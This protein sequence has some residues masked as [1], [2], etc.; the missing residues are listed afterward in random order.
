[1]N[2]LNVQG[3]LVVF[4]LTLIVI[5]CNW[6]VL[7]L[8]AEYRFKKKTDYND[9]KNVL[10]DRVQDLGWVL[11]SRSPP[12]R[13]NRRYSNIACFNISMFRRLAEES[14]HFSHHSIDPG[15]QEVSLVLVMFA[16][17]SFFQQSLAR[18]SG[19]SQIAQVPNTE[20][21]SRTKLFRATRTM[22]NVIS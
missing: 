13:K 16:V 4:S 8:Y 7:T 3:I 21:R 15:R 11:G 1:M 5:F 18:G 14:W 10:S 12:Q 20:L 9:Q 6:Y 19:I 22:H 2:C 17:F